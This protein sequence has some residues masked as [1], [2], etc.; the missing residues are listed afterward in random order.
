MFKCPLI[1]RTFFAGFLLSLL[2]GQCG[3]AVYDRWIW[4]DVAGAKCASGTATGFGINAHADS[5][6]LL[7][8]LEGGG[9]CDDMDTCWIHPKALNM[10]GYGS[11]EF[12]TEPK[13]K[14]YVI[15][16]R[17][18]ESG[19]P[20]ADAN[21]VF[22]PYCTGDYHSGYLMQSLRGGGTSKD[23]YFWGARDLDLF[24]QKIKNVLPNVDQVWLVGTS[25]GGVGTTAVYYKVRDAFNVRTD[26]INDSGTPLAISSHMDSQVIWGSQPIPHCETCTDSLQIVE[27]IRQQNPDSRYALLSFD[28]DKIVANGYEIDLNTF[29][30][31]LNHTL[32]EL[33]SDPNFSSF[34]VN[35][36]KSVPQHVVM[37]HYTKKELMAA[38]T[39]WLN[40]MVSDDIWPSVSY[41]P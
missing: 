19:N 9:S 21:M 24:L 39:G 7:I 27:S 34:T 12:A 41:Q 17:D 4:K 26:V 23:T 1:T 35:N 38:M 22:V 37:G 8:Y 28:Y 29:N 5:R 25:A 14:N 30:I 31:A 10:D 32:T 36:P 18:A 33:S 3:A 20:F 15:F 6:K 13:L 40:Q 11:A 2:S 16:D